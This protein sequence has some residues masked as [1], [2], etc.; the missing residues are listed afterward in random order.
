MRRPLVVSPRAVVAVLVLAAVLGALAAVGERPDA[1][2]SALGPAAPERQSPGVANASGAFG[3]HQVYVVGRLDVLREGNVSLPEGTALSTLL[4]LAERQGFRVDFDDN[5][6][7]TYDYVRG[8]DGL[9]ETASGGWN[10]YVR[11]AGASA[12]DWQDQ[13]AACRGLETGEDLLWCWVEPDERCA[14]YP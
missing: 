5:P 13:S 4:D 2:G 7:C 12:W 6:G 3:A 1:G 11:L 9:S 14:V 10:Y 8:I